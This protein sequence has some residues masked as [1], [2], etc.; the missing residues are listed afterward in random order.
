LSGDQKIKRPPLGAR[1]ASIGRSSSGLKIAAGG[2]LAVHEEPH[3]PAEFDVTKALARP[4][5][6][7]GG[8]SAGVATPLLLEG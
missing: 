3:A 4:T 6:K 8:Y 2:D 7:P 1:R 5:V